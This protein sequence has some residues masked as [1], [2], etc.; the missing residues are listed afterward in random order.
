MLHGLRTLSLHVAD[1][2]AARDWYA[3]A[4]GVQPYFDE[5]FYVGFDVAGYELGLQPAGEGE[6]VGPAGACTYWGVDDLPAAL[7][8]LC[9]RGA[10][11]VSPPQDVGGGIVVAQLCDPFGNHI[12]LIYNPVFK[13]ERTDG[14]RGPITVVDADARLAAAP[15]Q[16][17]ERMIVHSVDV[18]ASSAEIWPLWTTSAG[19][20]RWWV[21]NSRIEL[22]IGGSYELYFLDAQ[23]EGSKGSEGCRVL[24]FVPERMLSCTWNAP[25]DHVATRAQRTWWVLELEPTATGTRVTLRHL[26]WP[27]AM[28]PEWEATYAYFDAAWSRV[29]QRLGAFFVGG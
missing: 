16:L 25:P 26:G 18:A 22:Q 12:G 15:G 29:L 6:P 1:L 4:L 7:D 27:A 2:T 14:V 23:P 17:S 3:S 5:P 8:A 19:M 9:A 21:P 11:V 24:S 28:A 10:T 13:G 20:A